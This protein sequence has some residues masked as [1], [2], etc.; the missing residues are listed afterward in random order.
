LVSDRPVVAYQFSPLE[1]EA[2]GGRADKDWS[3]CPGCYSFSNDAS[4]LTPSTAMTGTYRIMASGVFATVG[5]Y[6]GQR[7]RVLSVTGTQDSTNVTVTL[8]A[9][10]EVVG[11]ASGAKGIGDTLPG[12]TLTF[13][14]NAGD[15]A[16]M[17]TPDGGDFD[18]SGSRL[19]ADKPVQVITSAPC[20]TVP[21]DVAACDH[22]EENVFPAETLGKRYAHHAAY[23]AESRRRA[24][25]KVLRRRQ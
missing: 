11:G 21:A 22:L 13:V 7:G 2:V 14:L 12:G 8:S 24:Y 4:L 10:A 19:T 18:F 23:F 3:R 20:A 25:C 17:T 15:V 6:G 16:Q 1:F 5:T 9:N